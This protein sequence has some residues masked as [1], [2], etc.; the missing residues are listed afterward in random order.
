AM[1]TDVLRLVR[2]W[3]EQFPDVGDSLPWDELGHAFDPQTDFVVVRMQSEPQFGLRIRP[4]VVVRLGDSLVAVEVSTAK[5][6]E[7]VPSA[8]IALNHFALKSAIL[9]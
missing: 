9:R 2:G 6:L 8:R 4:D 3:Q 5:T 1:R 7:A